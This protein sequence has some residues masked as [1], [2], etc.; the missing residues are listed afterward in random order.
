MIHAEMLDRITKKFDTA[1]EYLPPQ[2][3]LNSPK[4]KIGIINFGSTNVALNDA[5]Q[6]LT[7]NGIGINHLKFELFPFQNQLLIL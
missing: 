5:M 1:K 4:S 7:R 2:I 3:N 6:D